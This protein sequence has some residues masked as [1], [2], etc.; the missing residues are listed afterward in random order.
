MTAWIDGRP[1][2]F[3]EAVA[4]AA[5]LLREGRLPLVTG[6]FGDVATTRAA[7]DVSILCR[8][9]A[10]HGDSAAA[11]EA[12]SAFRDAGAFMGTPVEVRRRADL[13]VLVGADAVEAAPALLEF[14]VSR[15]PDLG[16][17]AT[18][19]RRILWIG[20]PERLPDLRD[21]PVEAVPCDAARLGEGL[22]AIRAALAGRRSG[23]GPMAEDAPARLAAQ[24]GAAAFGCV[25]FSGGSLS[26]LDIE[27]LEGLVSDLNAATRFT[28]LPV[29]SDG[30]AWGA[31]LLALSRTGFPLRTS[32]GPGHGDHDPILFE[33]ARL[34]ESGEA[35]V[36]LFVSARPQ[37]E[38]PAW[39]G[40]LPV[41]ALS[42]GAKAWARPPRV[43]F[44]PRDGA[45]GAVYD[46]LFGSF[47]PADVQGNAPSGGVSAAAILG[48]I[49]GRL[50]AEEGA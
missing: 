39:S 44:A 17:A 38:E 41:I 14:L 30:C 34:L 21:T 50:R 49:A 45:G 20:A 2:D 11:Y 28:S 6:P 12:I 5:N 9:V 35:D 3:A 29:L 25:V 43:A 31:A 18:R 36:A 19:G 10:D 46:P 27:T 4:T 22:G 40:S 32:F 37:D 33:G 42:R 47:R 24:M 48:A 13:L 23:V 7:L 15:A 16:A 8:G 1:A 26:S